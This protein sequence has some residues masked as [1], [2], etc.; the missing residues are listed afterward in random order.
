MVFP[1]RK[2]KRV[3]LLDDDA[4]IQK[5][6]SALLKRAG[7]RVDAVARGSQAIEALNGGA[8]DAILLDLM[9]PTEGGVTVVKHLQKENPALLKRVLLLTATPE[10]VLKSYARD[11]AGV[12]HKPFTREE[13]LGAVARVMK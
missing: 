11:V 2:A 3:L 1:L 6:V 10:S 5:L 4:A 8:Y 13:L 12:I 9:M 7:F